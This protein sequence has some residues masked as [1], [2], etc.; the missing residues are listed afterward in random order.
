MT[1]TGLILIT[2]N[3]R[4]V[5]KKLRIKKEIAP[6]WN[7]LASV[8][9]F[10]DG[11]IQSIRMSSQH[12]DQEV[13][14]AEQMLKKWMQRDEDGTWRKL[15]LKMRDVELASAAADLAKALRNRID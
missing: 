13:P 8:L 14:C 2:Y 11:E 3:D 6:K 4:G 9:G 1:S 10:S 5:E 7:E 12:Q 15:I